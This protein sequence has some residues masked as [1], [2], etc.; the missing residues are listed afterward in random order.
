M[1]ELEPLC[2]LSFLGLALTLCTTVCLTVLLVVLISAPQRNC[3]F[4]RW[5]P[6]IR[7][8]FLLLAP[9]LLILWP[10]VLF[11]WLLRSRGVDLDELD[12]YDD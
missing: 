2:Q 7:M 5:A 6:E 9:T 11:N 4:F 8:L 3:F 10:I 1:E 12:F